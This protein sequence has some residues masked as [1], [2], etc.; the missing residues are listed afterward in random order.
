[1]D[2]PGHRLVFTFACARHKMAGLI[3]SKQAGCMTPSLV[4]FPLEQC[5]IHGVR[6][7]VGGELGEGHSSN[8]EYVASEDTVA[9]SSGVWWLR[10]ERH[11]GL[12]GSLLPWN[13]YS[14]IFRF[15]KKTIRV[16]H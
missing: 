1:M 10:S 5:M 3:R 6:G 8:S 4:R 9:T 15:F 16:F 2:M 11:R 14:C 12:S 13:N 7:V